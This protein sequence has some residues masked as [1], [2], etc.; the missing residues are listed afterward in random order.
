MEIQRQLTLKSGD[1]TRNT[2]YRRCAEVGFRA[3]MLAHFLYNEADNNAT[4]SKVGRF[5]VW[6]AEM[7]LKEFV[8]RVRLDDD[9]ANG[10][11]ASAVYNALPSEFSRVELE[12][13]LREFSYKSPSSR[14]LSAWKQLGLLNTDKY[15]GATQ[16]MKMKC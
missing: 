13:K 4:R 9:T 12:C 1:R 7:M 10:F 5:A 8:V 15:Y 14:V 6:V 11:I 16:F 3:G 2:F